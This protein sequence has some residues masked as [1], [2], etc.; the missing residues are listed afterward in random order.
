MT[1]NTEAIATLAR[2]GAAASIIKT[3]DNRELL[4]L[5]E[6][7]RFEDVSDRLRAHRSRCRSISSQTVTM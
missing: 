2:K 4:I 5:P 1:E 6:G 3:A 7:A